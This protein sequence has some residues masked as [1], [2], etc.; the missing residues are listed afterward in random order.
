MIARSLHVLVLCG[1]RGSRLR[2]LTDTKPKSLVDVNGR[3]L[4]DSVLGCLEGQG[5][6]NV[7]LCTGFLGSKF[8]SY[9]DSYTGQLELKISYLDESASMNERILEA[10]RDITENSTILIVYGDTIAD[11][12]ISLL[13]DDFQK[14]SRL[15]M[16]TVFRVRS[17]FGLMTLEGKFVSSYEEKPM[18]PGFVNIGFMLLQKSDVACMDQFDSFESFLTGTIEQGLLRAHVHEGFH[19]T[20]NTLG[21]LIDLRSELKKREF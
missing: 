1:G 3:P 7:K 11:V 14:N 21:D 12:D 9:V 16:I 8:E 18:I 2:P 6:T 13:L 10:S 5:V 20:V 19:H 17:P 4:I 15:P